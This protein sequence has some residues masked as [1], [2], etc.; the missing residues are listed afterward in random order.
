M[1]KNC[2]HFW[3]WLLLL[4]QFTEF[5]FGEDPSRFVRTQAGEL[6]II[7]SAPHG[8]KMVVPDVV[9]RKGEGLPT[10]GSGFVVDRDTGTEELAQQVAESIEK[11]FGKKPYFVIARSHRK[12]LDPNRPPEIAYED[13]DAKP[14]YDAYHSALSNSCREVQQKFHKGLLLDIHGQGT[15]KDTVFRGTQNGKTVTLLRERFGET[16]QVGETSLF[17]RLQTHGWK[18][19]PDPLDGREQAAF[20]GGY[21]VQ[22]YGSH[23]GFGIDAIQLEFGA[24]YRAKNAREKTATTLTEAIAQ[25]ASSFLDITLPASCPK[26]DVPQ[27]KKPAAIQLSD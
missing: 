9:V 15:A 8:G 5:A 22:T 20:R 24:D 18:V 11:R 4:G 7:L 12:Y 6:P 17:G 21:I 26:V 10:G 25:Y 2:L 16:A 23:Q 3:L 14:I 13:A 1:T 19:H 27:P